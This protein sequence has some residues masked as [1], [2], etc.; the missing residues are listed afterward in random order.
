MPARLRRACLRCA[1]AAVVALALAL[2]G[3]ATHQAVAA[4][5]TAVLANDAAHN[6]SLATLVGPVPA[7]RPITVG[8]F[9][10]NPNQAAED[11]YVQQLYDPSSPNYRNF[12]DPDTFNTQFG[13]PAASLQAAEA[14]L[15]GA[16][17]TVSTVESSSDYVLATGTAAQVQAV[18][19]TPL[20]V[21]RANGETF[22]ANAVAPTVPASIG[23][24]DVL[25]SAYGSAPNMAG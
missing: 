6:L 10:A 25:G 22:Y 1:Q 19:G 13:V 11:A 7:G 14:W 23:V 20:N 4:A 3:G 2:F 15:Q 18:F 21:Y 12:L 16:G 24:G 5:G 17:L 9:L 8:V